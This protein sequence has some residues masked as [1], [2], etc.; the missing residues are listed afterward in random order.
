MKKIIMALFVL[1][2]PAIM[3]AN[4]G[5]KGKTTYKIDALKSSVAW[6]GYK[7]TGEHEGNIAIVSGTIH[8]DGDKLAGGEF[9]IDM[10]SLEVSGLDAK[11]QAKLEGH[12]KSGDF[13]GVEAHPNATLKITKVKLKGGIYTIVADLT[14]KD[15]TNPV[16]FE[17]T[18]IEVG[19][20]MKANS[21][22]T[23]DRSKYNVRYG[24]SSFF[25]NLGDK[26]IY[27]NFDLNVELVFSEQVSQ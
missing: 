5:D 2:L 13:F 3:V 4:N 12:L 22:I 23:I 24:S 25:D 9:I 19:G 7:V 16:E 27:D 11:M 1:S 26:A 17:T 18:I 8:M 15:I 14:I 21:K 6:K 20:M 10:T